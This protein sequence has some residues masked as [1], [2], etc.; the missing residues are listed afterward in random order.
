MANLIPSCHYSRT[1]RHS[2]ANETLI[3]DARNSYLCELIRD[4]RT[5][6]PT[7]LV[8]AAL[9]NHERT[10]GNRFLIDIDDPIA[11]DLDEMGNKEYIGWAERK[12]S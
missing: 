10:E 9:Q 8:S 5:T 11:N 3:G 6:D 7:R 1:I 12:E 4:A 2:V